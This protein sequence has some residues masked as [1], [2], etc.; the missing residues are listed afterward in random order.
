LTRINLIPPDE[1]TDQHLM[2]EW[3]EIKMIPASL[4]RSLKTKSIDDIL[5]SI[6]KEF[7]LG[8]GHVKFFYDKHEYLSD[9]YC[10][11]S[12]ELL[13]RG[14]KIKHRGPYED[15]CKDISLIFFDWYEPTEKDFEIIRNRIAEKINMKP[16]W[17]KF[18]GVSLVD[19][20]QSKILTPDY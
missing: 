6:P 1:L 11:L 18:Y 2:A 7:I 9:R 16:D 15:F 17:Y 10:D 20:R 5:K 12:K 19:I 8:K 14:Y 13:K 4:R 3:R